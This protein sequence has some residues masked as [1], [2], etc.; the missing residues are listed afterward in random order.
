MPR[1]ACT[2]YFK[3]RSLKKRRKAT[4]KYASTIISTKRVIVIYH[5]QIKGEEVAAETQT[6]LKINQ[7][8]TVEDFLHSVDQTTSLSKKLT[9]MNC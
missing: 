3:K 8:E 2:S 4:S 6:N 9:L 7:L 5:N 1:K